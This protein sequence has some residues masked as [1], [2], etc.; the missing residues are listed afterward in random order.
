MSA[1]PTA[2]RESLPFA[3]RGAVVTGGGRDIGAV[4]A[5]VLAGQGRPS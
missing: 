3:S 5:R 4:V 1:Q 2:R